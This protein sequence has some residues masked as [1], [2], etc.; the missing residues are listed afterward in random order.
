MRCWKSIEK[1]RLQPFFLANTTALHHM[2][3]SGQIVTEFNISHKCLWTSSMRGRSICLNH[4]L[5]RVSLVTLMTCLNEWDQLSLLS[6]NEKMS[7]YSAKRDWVEATSSGGHDSNPLISN[8]SN[9]FSCLCFIVNLGIWWPLSST[10]PIA[11]VTPVCSRGSGTQ[12]TL[13]ALT[14]GVFFFRGWG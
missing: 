13:T 7:W 10:S 11:L 6:S 4:S 1:C 2:L 8:S 9:N 14:T 3:W 5:N 12:V